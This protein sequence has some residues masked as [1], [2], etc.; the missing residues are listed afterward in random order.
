MQVTANTTFTAAIVDPSGLTWPLGARIERPVT[1]EI[2]SYWREATF[3]GGATW[4]V[5]IEAPVDPGEYLLVWRTGDPEPPE[6][7]AFIP[8]TA[9]AAALVVPVPFP[10]VQAEDVRPTLDDI[11]ALEQTRTASGGG[12]EARE[13]T[14]STRPNVDEVEN[15]ID[16]AVGAVL[17]QISE[18]RFSDGHYDGVKH[19]VALYTAMLIE[20]GYF[21]AS[22]EGTT[23]NSAVELWRTLFNQAIVNLQ[24]SVQEELREARRVRTLV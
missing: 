2:V 18:P 6:Y 24:S 8:L 1:R 9:V 10:I 7:E 23:A 3:D 4:T 13:F 15:L 22:M 16:Q 12:G 21:R 11:V 17:S 19:A 5:E 14:E 20:G